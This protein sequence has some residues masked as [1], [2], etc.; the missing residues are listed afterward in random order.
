MPRNGQGQTGISVPRQGVAVP[1][2]D[3]FDRTGRP[4]GGVPVTVG[5]LPPASTSGAPLGATEKSH[6]LK[7]DAASENKE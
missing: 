7:S 5:G 6:H 2:T 4:V 3:P 1:T